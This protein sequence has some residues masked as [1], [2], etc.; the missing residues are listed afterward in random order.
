M[1]SHQNIDDPSDLNSLR[2]KFYF[3][4]YKGYENK[5]EVCTNLIAKVYENIVNA[6]KCTVE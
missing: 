2:K 3:K 5:D 4:I 1:L 6:I